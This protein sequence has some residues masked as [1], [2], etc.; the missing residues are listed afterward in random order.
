MDVIE[1]LPELVPDRPQG[2]GMRAGQGPLPYAPS[3]Y[4][5]PAPGLSIPDV[6]VT[7]F[8]RWRLLLLALLL[9]VLLG[10]LAAL[11]SAPRYVAGTAL[12]VQASRESTG[13]PDLSGFG[14]NIQSVEL[15]KV[16]RTEIEIMESDDTVRR[17]LARIGPA[18]LYPDLGAPGWFGLSSAPAGDV[19]SRASEAFRKDLRTGTDANSNLLR[20][21]FTHPDRDLAIRALGAL[22]EAYFEQRA[23]LFQD[24]SSRFL[25]A[26]LTRYA[27]E[28]RD[29][30]TA[31]EGVKNERGILDVTQEI[32]FAGSRLDA[33]LKREDDLRQQR[34]V[35]QAQL[36]SA[37]GML[38]STPARV[39]ASQDRTNLSPNDDS[40][41][42]LLRLQQE[43]E[44]LAVQYAPG[45]PGL[46]DLDRRIAAAR[47][48]IRETSQTTF[49]TTREVRNP[50][51]ELLTTRVVS[52]QVEASALDQQLAELQQQRAQ[53]EVRRASLLE[54]ERILRDMQRRRDGLEAIYR[55]FTTRQAGTQVEEDARRQRNPNVQVLQQPTAPLA[56]TSLRRIFAAAGLLGGLM[57]ASGT[58][59][60]LSLLRGSFATPGEA[61]RGLTL[62][63]LGAF[64]PLERAAEKLR[65]QEE[66]AEFASLLLD[67]RVEQPVRGR[68][69]RPQVIQFVSASDDDGRD[70]LC[71]ALAVE[72]AM[73]RD[74]STLL[75]DLQ[76]DGR[77]HLAALGSQVMPVER[78]EGHVLAFSTV[79]P[80]LWISY[81]ARNSHLTDPRVAQSQTETLLAMLRREFDVVIV[82]GPDRS[83]SYAM[84]RLTA[85][86]DANVM[87]VRGERT[88]GTAAREF[89]DWVLASG[90]VLL[91]LVFT[92]R[93]RIMPAAV[94]RML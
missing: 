27:D 87:V 75:V 64:G 33:I 83:E 40:R 74:R 19:M 92:G 43:R 21:S 36:A 57:A 86:V 7:A 90:G 45:Y 84:R 44:R 31:I 72:L 54:G 13:T 81:D 71:R 8:L 56:G 55:Q 29:L 48:A 5:A 60:L 53:A 3:A 32:G 26:E 30:E 2:R 16:V 22:L 80:Q 12:A 46:A 24:G 68:A 25:G 15:L 63:S 82:I 76:H 20:V 41:N 18:T 38:N 65:D 50:S 88:R 4:G 89:R 61:E 47:A 79:I 67:A 66:V 1:Q 52:L 51:V 11:L 70:L 49:A 77:T 58:L 73:R 59:L 39:F 17:A 78:I 69:G 42:T 34:A 6:V 85:L 91:G 35:T 37:R 94:A 62:P 9:P 23:V 10:I 28:L 14:A 93:R